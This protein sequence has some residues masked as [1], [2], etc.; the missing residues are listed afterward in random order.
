MT[1][2]S[3]PVLSKLSDSDQTVAAPDEDVR[4]RKMADT[5]GNELGKVDDLLIDGTEQKVRFLL[6]EHGGF[7]GIGQ[8]KSFIPVDA[9]TRVTD[10]YVYIDQSQEQVSGA[11]P[12]DPDL[13]D[14]TAF[15][16]SVYDYYGYA[17]FWGPGYVYPG[18]PYYH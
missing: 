1:A 5:Q 10:D 11:P 3:T 14:E 12:Y 17:P 2:N 7:L 13:V 4:G 18:Y 9:V 6:V 8:K 16:G 15:Y